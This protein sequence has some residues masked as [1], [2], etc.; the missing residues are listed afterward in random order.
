MNDAV[1][2]VRE[3]DAEVV[4]QKHKPYGGQGHNEM[5]EREKAMTGFNYALDEQKYAMTAFPE[6]KSI[7]EALSKWYQTELGKRTVTARLRDDYLEGQKQAA[8]GNGYENLGIADAAGW[9]GAVQ[10]PPHNPISPLANTQF[11]TT[12]ADTD[13]PRSLSKRYPQLVTRENIIKLMKDH[14]VTFDQAASMLA[15]GGV[16]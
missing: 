12:A 9:A 6:S 10:G 14:G 13:E 1:K 15:R 2:R 3:G 16:E 7:G 5:A 11:G 4:F 8:V